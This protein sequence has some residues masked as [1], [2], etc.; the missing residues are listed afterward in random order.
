MLW[1]PLSFWVPPT[2]ASFEQTDQ[3]MLVL[4]EQYH[5]IIFYFYFIFICAFLV[6]YYYYTLLDTL[7]TASFTILRNTVIFN[8]TWEQ[9]IVIWFK[10]FIKMWLEIEISVHMCVDNGS[11]ESKVVNMSLLHFWV[12]TTCMKKHEF[13][14]LLLSIILQT[15][16]SVWINVLFI[17]SFE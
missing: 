17:T 2:T 9:W 11:N 8:K 15:E 1:Y 13:T 14:I 6:F 16:R 5:N 7:Y 3:V 10:T 4:I 12:N